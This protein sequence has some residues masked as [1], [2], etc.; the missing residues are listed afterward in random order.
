MVTSGIMTLVVLIL[1]GLT[2][3]A[4]LRDGAFFSAY[5]LVRNTLAFLFA[6]TLCEPAALLMEKIITS[7]PPAYDYF[8]PIC[9][10]GIFGIVFVGIKSFKLNLTVPGVRCVRA[11][12]LGVGGLFGLLGGVIATGALLVLWSMLPFVKYVPDDLGNARIRAKLL[13]TGTAALRFYSFAEQRLGGNA[14]FPLDEDEP[15]VIDN[16]GNGKADPGDQFEDWNNNSKW[17][18]SW[19]WRYRNHALITEGDISPL[20]QAPS[21][22]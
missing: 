6:M 3:Y 13:D 5:A 20:L 17:D 18:R 2:T 19:L 9:F 10:G 21:G 12:D 4:G 7:T 8:L 22:Q 1:L 15:L 11:I 16:N 14:P